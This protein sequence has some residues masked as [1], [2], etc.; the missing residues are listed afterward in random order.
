MEPSEKTAPELELPWGGRTSRPAK[1]VAQLV[2]AWSLDEP[3]RLGESFPVE[4]T[5]A[6]GRGTPLSDDPAP[7][8]SFVRSRP[9]QAT[10]CAPIATGNSCTRRPPR[11]T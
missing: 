4:Q 11:P 1:R 8:G 6:F 3:H 2:L 7:R 10:P 5:T 9:G